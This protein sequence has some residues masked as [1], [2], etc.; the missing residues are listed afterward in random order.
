MKKL[1]IVIFI[2]ISFNIFAQKVIEELNGYDWVNYSNEEK[3][4]LVR[5]Y[6]IACTMVMN[7][8]YETS[9]DLTQNQKELL[10]QQLNNQFK[11]DDSIVEMAIKLDDFYSSPSNRKFVIYRAIPFFGGKEWWNRK[12]GEVETPKNNG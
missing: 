4:A 5:G 6:Y 1:F 2:L 9:S 11:Y 7:L 3:V 8:F 12:T 10:I